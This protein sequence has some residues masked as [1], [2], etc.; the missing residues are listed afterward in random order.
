MK[1]TQ[2]LSVTVI[3]RSGEL[4]HTLATH[5]QYKKILIDHE[6]FVDGQCTRTRNYKLTDIGN[7]RILT[8]EIAAIYAVTQTDGEQV[9]ID[10]VLP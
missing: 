8:G 6:K 9:A 2:L 4:V 3:L 5:G 7:K 1:S 10:A